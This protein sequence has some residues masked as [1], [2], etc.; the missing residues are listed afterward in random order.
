MTKVKFK[1]CF[2]V[3]NGIYQEISYT[4][5]FI[6]KERNPEYANRYFLPIYGCL[7]EVPYEEYKREYRARRR[8]KYVN[9]IIELPNSDRDFS[10]L[11]VY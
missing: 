7:L 9:D 11:L 4:A 3:E 2:I 8:D 6:G 5:L 1:H 10:P